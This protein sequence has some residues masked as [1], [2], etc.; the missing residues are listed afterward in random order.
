MW[1]VRQVKKEDLPSLTKLEQQCFPVE[2]A[3]TKEAFAKRIELIPESFFVAEQNGEIIGL[4]NGPV[5]HNRVITDDLFTNIQSNPASG[6]HQS[7][8]GLAVS[9]KFQKHGIAAALLSHLEK[10]ARAQGRES[11]TLTC[12]ENLIS[13]YEKFGYKNAG[14]S[15]SDHGGVTWYNMI[16]LLQ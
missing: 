5:I 3:A 12:K 16:K 14:I 7:V 15:N 2:E 6:G 4:I 9:P 10:E 13:F 8:L 11:I 1:K